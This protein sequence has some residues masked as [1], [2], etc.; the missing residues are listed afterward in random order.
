M[1][2]DVTMTLPST[3]ICLHHYWGLSHLNTPSRETLKEKQNK[4]QTK[5]I[6]KV[7]CSAP[8]HYGFSATI[9]VLMLIPCISR[10]KNPAS[11]ELQSFAR[12]F[13][14]CISIMTP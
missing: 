12:N 2:S 11:S 6:Q 10:N 8:D 5:T 9:L 3:C 1:E 13:I 4:N 14:M 7:T